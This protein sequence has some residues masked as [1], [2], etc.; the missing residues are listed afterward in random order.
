MQ[1]SPNIAQ[2]IVKF[3][4]KHVQ[5]INI[6]GLVSI[7]LSV[8]TILVWLS[9]CLNAEPW[10]AL[11]GT[12]SGCFFGLRAVA[13]YLRESE[14]HISEMNSDE[15]IFFILT[16]E[17]DIDW[18]RINSDGKIEIYLRKHPALRFIMDEEPLNDDYIAPWANS[19][20]D[21]HAESYNFRLVLNG[22][23]L[24]N[25]TL[26]TVDGGRVEL[27][28][29]DLTT[30]KVFPFDYKIAQLFNISNSQFNSYMER[31]GLTVKV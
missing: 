7:L 6:M 20:P 16:T 12:L 15:I 11:F 9:T 17:R 14:K 5:A 19:F 25:T 26:V 22:N 4:D 3:I 2:P 23:L 13:D 18:H 1:K 28:Q 10:S 8:I 30:M 24:K 29:P 21:P 31:A 27:P